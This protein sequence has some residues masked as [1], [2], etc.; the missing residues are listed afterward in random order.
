[1]RQ[2]YARPRALQGGNPP[3]DTTTACIALCADTG[4]CLTPRSATLADIPMLARLHAAAWRETY[5][6]LLPDEEIARASNPTARQVQWARTLSRTECRTVVLEDLG[7]ACI[8][9]QRAE[10]MAAQGYSQELLSL[11]L[12]RIG[13]DRGHGKALLR[14]A[15]GTEPRPLTATVLASNARACG[16]YAALGGQPIATVTDRVGA[17]TVAEQVYAWDQPRLLLDPM[18][19]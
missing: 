12:L 1:V 2:D 16:F 3:A 17:V 5:A 7:F 19:R 9:P 15:L 13:Q 14:A 6:G 11:Y 18:L 8:G 10:A 4:F